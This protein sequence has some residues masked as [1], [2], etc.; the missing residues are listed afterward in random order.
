[1]P[2]AFIFYFLLSTR[3]GGSV[4]GTGVPSILYIKYQ[5]LSRQAF[6]KF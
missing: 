2:A 1:M 4:L 5:G 6:E 3:I